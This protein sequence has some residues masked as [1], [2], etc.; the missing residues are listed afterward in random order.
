KPR[1]GHGPGEF[2]LINLDGEAIPIQ[3]F[4]RRK[5]LERRDAARHY[6]DQDEVDHIRIAFHAPALEGLRSTVL[7]SRVSAPLRRESGAEVHGRT[8]SNAFLEVTVEP[9]GAIT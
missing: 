3:V 1:Q 8:L 2:A 4:S 6:P 5:A 9:T 7:R